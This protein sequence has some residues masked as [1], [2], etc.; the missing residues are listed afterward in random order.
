MSN[1]KVSVRLPIQQLEF[2]KSMASAN[3]TKVSSVLRILLNYFI[4]HDVQIGVS[5]KQ[6]NTTLNDLGCISKC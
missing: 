5:E 2:L 6:K 4:E 3:E 1:K